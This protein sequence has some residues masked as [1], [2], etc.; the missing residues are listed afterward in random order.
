[1]DTGISSLSSLLAIVTGGSFVSLILLFVQYRLNKVVA[2]DGDEDDD[3]EISG[4]TLLSFSS[5][6]LRV[7]MLG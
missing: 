6:T 1:M 2:G 5:S 7:C 3:N 4:Q